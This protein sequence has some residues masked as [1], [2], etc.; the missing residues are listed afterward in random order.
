MRKVL[1]QEFFNRDTKIVAQELI[2]KFLVRK[3][4]GKESAFM[5]TETEAYE[6]L[7]DRASHA[8][9]GLTKRTEI[10]FG[11]P[12]YFYIYLCYGLYYLLNVSTREKGLPAAVLI[13]GVLGAN[14][15]GKLT[16]LLNINKDLNGHKAA[17][18]TGLWIED[19]GTM[20]PKKNIKRTPRVGVHYAGELWA[21]KK[22]RYIWDKK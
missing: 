11:P 22:L 16:R 6:G 18:S 1:T 10:M 7:K 21:N 14:G 5:I 4:D 20:I 9:K 3:E 2:G 19:R 8:F 15:P 13:R 12:G 17:R